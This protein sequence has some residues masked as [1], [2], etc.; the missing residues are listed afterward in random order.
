MKG[1]TKAARDAARQIIY[2]AIA[3]LFLSPLLWCAVNAVKPAAESA[4]AP[5]TFLPSRLSFD[6]YTKLVQYGAG[7]LVYARNSFFVSVLTVLFTCVLCVLAGYGFARLNFPFKNGLFLIIFATMVIPFQTIL[8]PLFLFMNKIGLTN[9]LLGLAIIYT[10]FQIA[11]GTFIMRNTFA[12]LP[13]EIEEAAYIDGCASASML[14]RIMLP[15]GAPGIVTIC[16]YAFINSWN[17]FLASLIFMSKESK[18]TLPVMLNNIRTGMYGA[19]DWGSLQ[20][21]VT[22][23]IVPCIVL[24]VCLQ[25]Y[26]ISGLTNGSVKG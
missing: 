9:S 18:F 24:F 5:P 22:V 13:R 17:E 23:M 21:G 6:N 10:V 16:I 19:I 12:A 15:L 11:F 3:L 26:Y 14:V 8:T 7:V 2:M 4:A 1:F 20:A 25:K